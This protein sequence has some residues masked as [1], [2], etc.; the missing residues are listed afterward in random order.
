MTR[1]KRPSADDYARRDRK[2]LQYVHRNRIGLAEC[3]SAVL[4]EGKPCGHVLRKLA[5]TNWL[6]ISERAIPGNLSYVTLTQRGYREIGFENRIPKS[7]SNTVLS[8]AIAI[9]WYCTLEKER[10]FWIS[11]SEVIELFGKSSSV[12]HILC[13]QEFGEPVVLRFYHAVGSIRTAKRYVEQ[14][15][16]ST[17]SKPSFASALANGSYGLLCLAPTEEKVRQ[18]KEAFFEVDPR[19]EHRLVVGLG[20]TDETLAACLRKRRRGNG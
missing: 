16:D 9:N 11:P 13:P 17:S 2:L 7:V 14:F 6:E 19:P 3:I 8:A 20:P 18:L 12:P 5:A 1:P 15:F 4:F 10:R